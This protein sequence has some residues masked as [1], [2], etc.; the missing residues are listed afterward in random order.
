MPK[1]LPQQYARIL[2][3][4]TK[5]SSGKDLD[6]AVAA[7]IEFV[8]KEQAVKKMDYILKYFEKYAKEQEGIVQLDIT[9]ARK[10]SDH[11]INMI[12]KTFGKKVEIEQSIDESIVGGVVVRS[13]NTVL[14][15]SIRTQLER[16]KEEML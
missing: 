1:L 6:A 15:G 11:T 12:T 14:D 13:K 3:N 4:V 8:K 7:F 10:L 2:Y 16:L 9:S 5:D